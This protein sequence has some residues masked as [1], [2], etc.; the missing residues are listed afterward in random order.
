MTQGHTHGTGPHV[1]ASIARPS[2]KDEDTGHEVYDKGTE[3]KKPK[4]EYPS[5]KG[6]RRLWDFVRDRM[7]YQG[8]D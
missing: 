8:E 5:Y 4:L 7:E 2:Q 6:A 1:S 3:E